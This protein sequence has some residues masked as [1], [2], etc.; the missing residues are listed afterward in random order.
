MLLLD[1]SSWSAPAPCVT[2][3]RC[4]TVPGLRT[5][6]VVDAISDAQALAGGGAAGVVDLGEGAPRL[7][8]P[9]LVPLAGVH[10]Q[11][12]DQYVLGCFLGPVTVNP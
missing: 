8:L 1:C 10:R 12:L 6:A 3:A 11:L 5:Q 4:H 7:S 9:R 2:E